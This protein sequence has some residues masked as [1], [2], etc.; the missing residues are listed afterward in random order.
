ME[1]MKEVSVSGCGG[2]GVWVL[3]NLTV[4]WKYVQSHFVRAVTLFV[5]GGHTLSGCLTGCLS[6][7]VVVCSH[8]QSVWTSC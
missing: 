4:R 3:V 7:C 5:H 6:V 1:T 2:V 8:C